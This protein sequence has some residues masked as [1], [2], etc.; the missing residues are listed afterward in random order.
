MT[1]SMSF[2][3]V[4]TLLRLPSTTLT[5]RAT[6]AVAVASPT[7][8]IQFL[9]TGLRIRFCSRPSP[10]WLPLPRTRMVTRVSG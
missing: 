5:R 10:V 1:M 2:G 8:S 3:S 6:S 4:P 9:N 7:V